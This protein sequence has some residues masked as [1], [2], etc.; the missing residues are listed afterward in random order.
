MTQSNL[1][2]IFISG[3]FLVASG[4]CQTH[5]GKGKET[6]VA[7]NTTMGRIVVELYDE[8]PKTRDNFLKLV[9]SNFYDS[10]LFHRVIKEFMIQ[11]G[12]PAS[13]HAQPAA[14]LGNGDAGYTVPAEFVPSLIHK[15]GAIAMARQGDD[16]NPTKASSGCQFYI[17]QGKV[18]TNEQLDRYEKAANSGLEQKVFF[19]ILDKPENA[20]VKQRFIQFQNASS[21]DSLRAIWLQFQP[22][23]DSIFA[24]MPHF[25]FT[26]EQR[27]AYTTV[28][29]A[30]HL[31]G[32]YTV[33]GEVTAGM[34]VVD[35]IA[36]V[37]VD[38]NNRPLT[39]VRILSMEIV[40]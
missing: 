39:D 25:S 29:G 32:S 31:D 5:T 38:S 8:T 4:S 14:L 19:Q 36:E 23:T 20:G 26:P 10:T 17:V 40:K 30:P 2:L 6:E 15:K 3:L 22:E 34:D 35:K 1:A 21:I 9:R 13:K 28:G 33:F 7:I 16:V 11:A 27:K 12:D 18:F 37:P 24:K